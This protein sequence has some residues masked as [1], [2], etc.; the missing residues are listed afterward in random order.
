LCRASDKHDKCASRLRDAHWLE[1]LIQDKYGRL[2]HESTLDMR[3]LME[4]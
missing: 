1:E 4:A 2:Q 3:A